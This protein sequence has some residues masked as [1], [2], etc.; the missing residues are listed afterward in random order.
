MTVIEGPKPQG[1][2][3]GQHGSQPV[4]YCHAITIL[5]F[6]MLANAQASR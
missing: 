1:A 3:A 6:H 5:M 2:M 4:K